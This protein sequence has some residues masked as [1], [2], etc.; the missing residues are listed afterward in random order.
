[1]VQR[2]CG[3]RAAENKEEKRSG[4][5]DLRLQQK[6]TS[7]VEGKEQHAGAVIKVERC[8]A[9]LHMVLCHFRREE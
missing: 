8:V 6:V 2:L 3:A 1:M 5:R 4:L 7:G 9:A